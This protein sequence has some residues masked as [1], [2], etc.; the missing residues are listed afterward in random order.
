MTRDW[1]TERLRLADDTHDPPED[2]A[3][4]LWPSVEDSYRRARVDPDHVAVDVDGATSPGAASRRPVAMLVV[5]AAV[6]AMLL[7]VAQNRGNDRTET[8]VASPV[9]VASPADSDAQPFTQLCAEVREGVLA[10]TFGQDYSRLVPV[11][12][13]LRAL[14]ARGETGQLSFTA[15]L[16]GALEVAADGFDVAA[17]QFAE[18]DTARASETVLAAAFW[19]P[20]GGERVELGSLEPCLP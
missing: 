16:I 7:A 19:R 9:P 1:L 11:A 8:H 4:R 12:V 15:D 10:I 20:N 13:S 5:A 17:D 6:V 2:L 18:G 3:D 14:A